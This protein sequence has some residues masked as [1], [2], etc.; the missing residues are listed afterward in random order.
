MTKLVTAAVCLTVLCGC[1]EN[2]PS[3]GRSAAPVPPPLATE[4]I[5]LQITR[6]EP[7]LAG[8]PFRVLLD[9]ESP[10]D[11]AFCA[12]RPQ[13]STAAAHTGQ[14]ALK[15]DAAAPVNVKLASLVSG[16][17]FPGHWT[18][19]G[20][21]FRSVGGPARVTLDYR[22]P[23][24]PQPVL[25][26]SVDLPDAAQWTGV[27][28]DLASLAAKPQA[29][30][31]QL[32]LQV[33]G[34][35]AL[36]DDVL[37][38]DN[39]QAFVTPAPTDEPGSTWTVRQAGFNIFIDRPQHFRIT[40]KTPDASPEGWTVE[41]SS[42]VRVR[43]VAAAGKFWT[44]YA[45][46]RQ[47]KDAQFSP[48]TKSMGEAAAEYAAQHA[49]PATIEVADEFGRIDRDTPGDQNNDGYNE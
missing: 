34:A 24:S 21:Y 7:R 8:V 49:S 16:G 48:I 41:E 33:E 17:A 2:A 45:D 29:E 14:T 35:A 26:R 36:C 46:G 42:D 40:L 13:T 28:L 38:V 27:F 1:V 4:P 47:Y 12:D 30:V 11:L 22:V 9:F 32:T 19:I 39:A 31:G 5:G 44:L 37:L 18:M 10:S 23:S 25:Q 15:L 43:L 3:Q 20:G 6:A